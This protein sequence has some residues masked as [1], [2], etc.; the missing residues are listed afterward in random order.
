M[1]AD[2][3]PNTRQSPGKPS[4][5]GEEELLTQL[6]GLRTPGEHGRPTES[7]KQGS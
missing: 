3:Q 4:E 1:G 7:T 6:A 2:P 5:E